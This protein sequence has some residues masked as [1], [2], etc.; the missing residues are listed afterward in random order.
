MHFSTSAPLEQLETYFISH[1]L[2]MNSMN[3]KGAYQSYLQARRNIWNQDF[4]PTAV[5]AATFKLSAELWHDRNV[6][7]RLLAISLG[8]S[9]SHSRFIDE[10]SFYG[11][12]DKY[13]ELLDLG[14]QLCAR[15]GVPFI[16]RQQYQSKL[17][18][19]ILQWKS[20]LCNRLAT[21]E[22]EV[23]MK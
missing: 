2:H 1:G 15:H 22:K 4:K 5:I 9:N 20:F 17:N 8:A 13:C 3:D 7:G 16:S 6:L 23:A 18:E 10:N 11:V 14:S 19:S 21:K 12:Y